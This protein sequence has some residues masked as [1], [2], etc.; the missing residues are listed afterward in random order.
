MTT[1]D[2]PKV[3][4]RSSDDETKVVVHYGDKVVTISQRFD[5]LESQLTLVY[6]AVLVLGAGELILLGIH[7]PEVGPLLVSLVKML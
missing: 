4:V 6:K 7:L 1:D 5:H 2:S 3:V